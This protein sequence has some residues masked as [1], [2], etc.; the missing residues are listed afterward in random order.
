MKTF[1]I[2]EW[3]WDFNSD[4]DFILYY[5]LILI[6]LLFNLNYCFVRGK[7][8]KFQKRMAMQYWNN[9]TCMATEL[10]NYNIFREMQLYLQIYVCRY[11]Y[12]LISDIHWLSYLW[13]KSVL[14]I[15]VFCNSQYNL[16]SQNTESEA[17][18]LHWD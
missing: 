10:M 15:I 13:T 6:L 8:C 3:N 11:A 18:C 17:L 1:C 7:F 16:D 4:F 14:N 5:R 9:F 2:S 12:D